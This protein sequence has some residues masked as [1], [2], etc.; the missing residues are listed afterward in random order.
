MSEAGYR[1]GIISNA[2]DEANVQRLIEKANVRPYFQPILISAALG[3]R[4]PDPRPF[5]LVLREWD[6]A[7]EEVVMVGD[8]LTAD[9]L[10]A[11]NV[12]MR[13][14]WMKTQAER[15]DN[16]RSLAR[17]QP[18]ATAEGLADLPDLIESL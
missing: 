11:Q 5:Q 9:I 3:V 16:L 10:G 14:I 12:S 13:G 2:G 15:E 4:K 8:T 1:L 18:D 17:V 7:A 6:L